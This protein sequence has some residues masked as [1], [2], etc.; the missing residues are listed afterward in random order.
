MMCTGMNIM[1]FDRLLY[2]DKYLRANLDIALKY[3]RANLNIAIIICKIR[4]LCAVEWHVASLS[5][6]VKIFIMNTCMLYLDRLS[7]VILS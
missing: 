2:T 5:Q 3:L 4:E 1:R 6:M 7:S